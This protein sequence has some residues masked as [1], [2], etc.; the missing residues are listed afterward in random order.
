MIS[1]TFE[2]NLNKL[3][4]SFCRQNAAWIPDVFHNFYFMEHRKMSYKPTAMNDY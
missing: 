1:L 2:Q 4:A 3:A